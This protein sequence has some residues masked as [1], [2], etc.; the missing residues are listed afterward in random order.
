MRGGAAERQVI[1]APGDA[2]QPAREGAPGGGAGWRGKGGLRPP[3]PPSS[4]PRP[5][6]RGPEAPSANGAS[7]RQLPASPPAPPPTPPRPRPSPPRPA[8]GPAPSPA[9][10]KL[11]VKKRFQVRAPGAGSAGRGQEGLGAP[12]GGRVAAAGPGGGGTG[13][14]PAPPRRPRRRAGRAPGGS[15]A[16]VR[17]L[18]APKG[19][20]PR[21]A[22][23]PAPAIAATPGGPP[24]AGLGVERPRASV[25]PLAAVRPLRAP[26]WL[27]PAPHSGAFHLPGLL[28]ATAQGSELSSV[29]STS[30]AL[31]SV[32]PGLLLAILRL[33][34]FGGPCPL[35]LHHPPALLTPISGV[36]PSPPPQQESVS[37]SLHLPVIQACPPLP[38][39]SFI[40]VSLS[41]SGSVSQVP[42]PLTSV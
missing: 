39:S 19:R 33:P 22:Q 11:W 2:G 25:P 32:D 26:G 10:K 20:A 21:P 5:G 13:A 40:S 38:I 30:P 15:P 36:C 18:P 17:P 3:P 41:I 8:A 6:S 42:S 31:F 14:E 24:A 16:Y 9:M 35:P 29:H 28:E 4:S 23:P 37:L 34:S 7:P 27:S 12:E 1:A